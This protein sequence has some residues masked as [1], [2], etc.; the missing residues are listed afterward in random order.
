MLEM[1]ALTQ[2]DAFVAL[3][4]ACG[5]GSIS[6]R[7]LRR[8]PQA[9]VIAVDHDPV[10][11][12]IAEGALADHAGR[13]RV[14]DAD[15]S[16]AGWPAAAGVTEVHAVLSSTALHWLLPDAL[17][18][19][20]TQAAQLLVSGGIMLNADH[21]R[22]DGRHPRLGAAATA[23]DD[24][25]QRAAFA[26]GARTWEQWW[27]DVAADRALAE[28]LPERERR[29]SGR[30]APPPTAPD[31]HFAALRQAGFAEVATVWQ[32]LD[33]YVVAAVR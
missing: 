30:P 26:A 3:D 32:Y 14:V 20:Y 31:L 5:P 10:L 6:A 23:H 13:F 1:L 16:D 9:T 29:F 27:Q 21:L 28:L 8:F 7:V 24:A 4:V 19:V 2:P 11:L 17:V 33:D 25:T 22:F 15:L 18:R 12:R